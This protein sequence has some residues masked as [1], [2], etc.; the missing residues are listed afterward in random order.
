MLVFVTIRPEILKDLSFLNDKR[1]EMTARLRDWCAINSGSENLAGLSQMRDAVVA[2]FSDLDGE[3]EIL[4]SRTQ[5]IVT[6][7]GEERDK[8]IGDMVR[9][10]KNP[11]AKL[12]VLL[13]GHM[14]TVFG[15]DHP[16]QSETMLDADTMNAPGAADMKGGLLVMLYALKTIERSKFGESI[17]YEV[18]INADEETGSHGSAHALMDAAARAHFACVYEPSLPDGSLAGA[19]KGS[20]N[21]SAIFRGRPA[22]AGRDHHLGR[23]AIVAASEFVSALAKLTGEREG[24]TVNPAR[25]EGGGAENVVPDLAI[26]RFNIRLETPDDADWFLRRAR[27][28]ISD[29]DGREGYSA[30]LVGGVS[31]P[32]KPMTPQLQRFFEAL[33]AVGADLDLAIDWKPTGGC[34]DGNNIAAAG[35]P[36]IDTL[37]VRGAN[38]H[39]ANEYAKLDSLVERAK[40]S[41]LLLL[42]V[43][44]GDLPNPGQSLAETSS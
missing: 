42:K 12:R 20:G 9:I 2:A 1:A 21:F 17:G 25:I 38:I 16:F 31:R 4:P 36:V 28:L 35:A 34:C 19:R 11:Q 15:S 26:V 29:I 10:V 13:A 3:V 30:E 44:A 27:G 23:N 6:P 41:A 32:P 24:F 8:P 5:R 14:D 7:E 18:I 43:A 22:H 37:G 40:L 39:S 33:R